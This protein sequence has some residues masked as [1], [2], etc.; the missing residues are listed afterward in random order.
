MDIHTNTEEDM[1]THS[2]HGLWQNEDG[3]KSLKGAGGGRGNGGCSGL[4]E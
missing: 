2:Q 4:E 3:K 1:S